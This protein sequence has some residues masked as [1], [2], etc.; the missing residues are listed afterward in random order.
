MS[1]TAAQ[2]LRSITH[3]A[4]GKPSEAYIRSVL[5]RLGVTAVSR[6]LVCRLFNDVLSATEVIQRQIECKDDYLKVKKRRDALLP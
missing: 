6:R 2:P 5:D 1:F 4:V 3:S